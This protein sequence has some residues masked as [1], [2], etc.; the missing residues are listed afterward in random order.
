MTDNPAQLVIDGVEKSLSIAATW[1][2]W[3]GR[4]IAGT[5]DGRPN[6]WTPLIYEMAGPATWDA[7]RE[8]AWTLREIADHVSHV[9]AYAEY[10][11]RLM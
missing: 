5:L 10:V 3:D 7:P 4:P 8:P 2:A 9:S 11:G 1:H 6:V